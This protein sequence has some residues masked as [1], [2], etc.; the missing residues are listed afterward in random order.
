MS[1]KLNPSEPPFTQRVE[2]HQQRRRQ[3]HRQSAPTG[4]PSLPSL[5]SS[6]FSSDGAKPTFRIGGKM[7]PGRF[8]SQHQGRRRAHKEMRCSGE[9]PLL[10]LT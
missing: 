9:S 6:S 1:C 4:P 8:V 2:E 7:D 3:R 5:P 10:F